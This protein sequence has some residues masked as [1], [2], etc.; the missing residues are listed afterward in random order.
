MS[1]GYNPLSTEDWNKLM[2]SNVVSRVFPKGM[3]VPGLGG[4]EFGATCPV[5]TTQYLQS[6][7]VNVGFNGVYIFSLYTD[8]GLTTPTN[9]IC[10]YVVSGTFM[11]AGF[12]QLFSRTI[13]SG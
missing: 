12:Q 10:D 7:G 1:R 8:S 5:F 9:A 11:N 6:S 2:R 4:Q 3:A 13:L